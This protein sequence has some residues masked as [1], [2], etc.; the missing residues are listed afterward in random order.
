MDS[1]SEELVRLVL[2]FFFGFLS[3][4]AS[5]RTRQEIQCLPYARFFT[6]GAAL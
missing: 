3:I 6:I 4:G 1:R 2:R 5:I